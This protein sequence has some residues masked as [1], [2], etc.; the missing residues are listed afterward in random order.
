MKRIFFFAPLAFALAGCADQARIYPM[1]DVALR[2]GTPKLEFVR[3]GMG[4]GPVTI[5]M[6]NG[7]VL[8]G[9]YQITENAAAAFGIAGGHTATA[10]GYGSGRH[11]VI[12]AVGDRGTIMN[13]EATT[14]IAGHG[15]GI[16]DGGPKIGKFRAMY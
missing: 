3:Q 7:E 6:P 12:T 9:E 15:S 13:C 11:T 4:R 16:C 5:T 10:I 2:V 8:R 1:D 14:D